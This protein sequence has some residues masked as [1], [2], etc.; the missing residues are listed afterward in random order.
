MIIRIFN[1]GRGRGESPVDYLLS[2]V[3]HEGNYRSAAPDVLEGEPQ[4]TIDII[5]GIRREHRYVSGVMAFRR[6]E[7][8]SRKQMHGIIRSFRDTLLAGLE[9]D[10][11]NALFVLHQDKGNTEIHFI[12]PSVE[13]KSGRR[14]NI[15]PPGS[16]NLALYEAFTAV[17]NHEHGYA[18]VTPDP[19]RIAAPQGGHKFPESADRRRARRLLEKEITLAVKSG[20]IRSKPELASWLQSELGVAVTRSGQDYLSVRMPGQDQTMR[21]K[22]PLFKDDANYRSLIRSAN[23]DTGTVRLTVPEYQQTRARLERLIAER[24][25]YHRQAFTTRNAGERLAML[26][27]GKRAV[28]RS[29]HN[30]T[31]TTREHTMTMKYHRKAIE[32]AMTEVAKATSTRSTNTRPITATAVSANIQ[33]LR[34][35]TR[36]SGKRHDADAMDAIH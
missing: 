30:T 33:G 36:P 4:T 23:G 22:G 1:T 9:D 31:T 26:K 8:P 6:E 10:R 7:R 2:R 29:T 28:E 5:N 12:V 34:A 27:A 17:V 25:N 11:Y 32:E 35:R 20:D 3:D 16:T 15:H 19:F 14:L 13:L 24:C 18:Q 21:L